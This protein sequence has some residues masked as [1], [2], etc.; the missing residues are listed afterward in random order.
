MEAEVNRKEIEVQKAL[1]NLQDSSKELQRLE[2]DKASLE[3]RRQQHIN[4]SLHRAVESAAQTTANLKRKLN[5]I[6]LSGLSK[7]QK[8]MK[9]N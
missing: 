8:N 1:K 9:N 4:R 5:F 7:I 2:T 3:I 6:N